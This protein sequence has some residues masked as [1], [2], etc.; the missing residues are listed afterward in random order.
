MK[1]IVAG[2][3]GFNDYELMCEK[4][5]NYLSNAQDVEIVCGGAR[6]ADALG[7]KYA[8][9]RGYKIANFPADWD[10]YGNAAGHIR[11]QDMGWYADALVAFWD[12]KSAGT[13]NMIKFMTSL[14]KP[15]KTVMYDWV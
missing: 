3:R 13:K 11:N 7:A 5:D 8:R 1:V 9:E 2:G 12:G 6:G 14:K 10:K 15:M 4:L